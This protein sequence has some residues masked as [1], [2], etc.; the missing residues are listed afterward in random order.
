MNRTF[1]T[2]NKR[3]LSMM[4]WTLVFLFIAA[5]QLLSGHPSLSAIIFFLAACMGC[6]IAW[7]RVAVPLY[8]LTD[9]D[10]RIAGVFIGYKHVRWQDIKDVKQ[11]DDEIRLVGR[12]WVGSTQINLNHLQPTERH[13]FVQLVQQLVHRANGTS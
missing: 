12:E 8:T 4:L 5:A 10:I 13:D 9:E 7:R 1:R 11:S 6:R 3:R 2:H